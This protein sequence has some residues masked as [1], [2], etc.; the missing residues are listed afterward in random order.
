MRCSLG[1]RV[2]QRDLL[3][4]GEEEHPIGTTMDVR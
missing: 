4:L 2:L 1:G 3:E